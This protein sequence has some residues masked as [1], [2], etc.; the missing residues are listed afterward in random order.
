[1]KALVLVVGS[2]L[3]FGLGTAYAQEIG[4]DVQP[5]AAIAKAKTPPT[6]PAN[7]SKNTSI[8]KGKAKVNTA[9]APG[10]DD[11]FWVETLDLD[12]DGTVEETDFIYD[13][14]DKVVYL[15]ADGDF[16]CKGGGTGTGGLLIAVNT[17]GNSRNR[18]AGSGWYAAELDEGECKAKAAGLYGCKFDADGNATACG[19]A[20]IDEK[21]DDIVIVEATK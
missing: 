18:P 7:A 19:L 2:T 5:K 6:P 17:A 4:V 13:D 15:Y 11:S 9:N 3:V 16:K 21:N 1:M 10:D 12:G 14:E 20:T 8:G